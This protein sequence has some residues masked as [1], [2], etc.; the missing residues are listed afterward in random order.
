MRVYVNETI[1]RIARFHNLRLMWEIR[2]P[3][4]TEI[5]WISCYVGGPKMA[6]MHFITYRAGGWDVLGQMDTENNVQKTLNAIA[7]HIGASAV[8]GVPALSIEAD[9]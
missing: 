4:D 9:A 5:A 1:K 8:L 3:K 6:L 7:A 2:G